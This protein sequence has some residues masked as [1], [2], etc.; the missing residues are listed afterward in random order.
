MDEKLKRFFIEES[1]NF[2][3]TISDRQVSDI[4]TYMDMLKERNKVIN[5]TAIE[6]DADILIK[7]FI[8]SLT[9]L[10][11]IPEKDCDFIDVGTGAGFPGMVIKIIR[12]DINVT[13]LDAVNKKLDF[14]RDVKDTLNLRKINIIHGRAEELGHMEDFREKFDIV[15]ARAVAALPSLC[16]YCIP[17]L[18]K[19]GIFIAMKGPKSDESNE[20]GSAKN[21]LYELGSEI[22]AVNELELPKVYAKRNVIIIKKFRHTSTRYPRRKGK[23]LKSPL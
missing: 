10:K 8:D 18:K 14:L 20:I 23:I 4:E 5:L 1:R 21:A 22:T 19:D 3:E 7:H 16:E 13:L 12:P 2:I 11:Y 17:F 6:D 9:I 15:S